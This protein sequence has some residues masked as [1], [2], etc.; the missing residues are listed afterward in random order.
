MWRHS[1]SLQASSR[2][3]AQ[4]RWKPGL[5]SDT[6]ERSP[7][8]WSFRALSSMTQAEA[9][10]YAA[11]LRDG[12]ARHQAG[13]LTEAAVMYRQVLEAFPDHPD[14]LDLYGVLLHQAGRNDA[15]LEHLER[16]V[17][18]RPGDPGFHNHLGVCQQ[19][20]GMLDQAREAFATAMSLRPDMPEP[21]LNLASVLNQLSR[22]E[23]AEQV[24]RDAVRLAPGS[25][26]AHLALVVALRHR[27]RHPEA[28]E[29]LLETRRSCPPDIRVLEQLAQQFGMLGDIVAAGAAA[30]HAVLFQP[31]ASHAYV[32]LNESDAEVEWARRAVHLAPNDS[33]LWTNLSNHGVLE[34]DNGS[35]IL[36]ARHAM[37]L[38]PGNVTAYVNM[39]TSSM[40]VFDLTRAR[41]IAYRGM[42]I[43]PNLHVLAIC[44]SE[45]ERSRGNIAKGWA[46]YERRGLLSEALPRLGLP[47]AWDRV[48][49]LDG[50][51]LVCAEQGVGDE[52]IF[53]NCLPD[54]LSIADDV[55]VEC[56]QR[57][58]SLFRRTFPTARWIPRTIREIQPGDYAWDYREEARNLEP[59]SH[60]MAASLPALF[61]AGTGRPATKSG[62][63]RV[64]PTE[65]TA[66]RSWLASLPDLPK[67]GVSWRSGV[68]DT[69]HEQYYFTPE[70]LLDSIGAGTA[71]FIS[72]LYAD[73]TEEIAR[74]RV[75]RDTIIHE[76]PGL[77][78]RD[79]LDRL[80]ALIS[81]LDMVVTADTSV[82]AMAAACGVRTIRLEASYMLLANGRDALFEN[83]YPC[84]DTEDV[85]SRDRILLR[86]AQKFKE[87]MSEPGAGQDAK[88]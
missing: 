3:V 63:L 78:Q 53:L 71:T 26:D 45:C 77:Y 64:D 22:Y 62:Y 16:A 72:L 55:I 19:A 74:I 13:Q 56:D 44:A 25:N 79:E 42:S 47:P 86:A 84:R 27:E 51:L 48:T 4:V 37:V 60:I 75:S 15:A 57:C 9:E 8:I 30:R 17:L 7:R 18:A 40:R 1:P 21:A 59:E 66:W 54:L 70:M 46:L 33:R 83:L 34:N 29:V 5:E 52:F 35:A 65:A 14:T 80:A 82:C 73:A 10:R 32:F 58:L 49:P 41:S 43:D 68:V 24:A 50:S 76:P 2:R 85:F 61:H 12:L 69:L 28:V 36:G 38:S 6:V 81:R 39:A 67:V 20:L 23:Q 87:W 31:S 11:L 88:Y